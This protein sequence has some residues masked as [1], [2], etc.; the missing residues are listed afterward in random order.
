MLQYNSI[1]KK[2]GFNEIESDLI[3]K[4]VLFI[5]ELNAQ[6]NYVDFGDSDDAKIINFTN[7]KYNYYDY[8]LT[9]ASYHYGIDFSIS[10]NSYLEVEMF[11]SRK[12]I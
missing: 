9:F 10:N 3:K 12:K 11:C 4:S 5:N 8:I 6:N 7:S 2:I 1:M